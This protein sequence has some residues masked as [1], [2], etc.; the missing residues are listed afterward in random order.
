M[1]NGEL[2][3]EK[4]ENVGGHWL[5]RRDRRTRKDISL[6]LLLSSV[7]F[8]AR[9]SVLGADAAAPL[10]GKISG[11][12]A[13]AGSFAPAKPLPVFKNRDFCGPRVANETLIVGRDGGVKNAVVILR[14]LDRLV[15]GKSQQIVLDNQNCAF[16]P[17]VQ[18]APTGSEVLLKNSD[19]ILHTVHARLGRETLFNVGL[20]KWRTVIKRLDRVGV[21][22]IDCDVLHTWMSAA[23]VV[24]DSPYFALSDGDGW[25]SIG[26]VPAG[27]YELEVWHERLGARQ[28]RIDL[29]SG[30]PVTVE[31]VFSADQLR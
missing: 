6:T 23:I 29:P 25:F 8:F 3:I 30:V 28:K 16:V 4:P 18:V 13:L 24:T 31:I 1:G 14:V 27:V 11:R 5:Q 21:V 12:I 26:S 2:K 20:P 17:H 7:L 22:R 10:L 15:S 9:G 19:P